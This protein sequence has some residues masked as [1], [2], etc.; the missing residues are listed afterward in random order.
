MIMDGTAQKRGRG[1]EL[2][3]ERR[4]RHSPAR[5]WEWLTQPERLATWL[6]DVEID[7]QRGGRYR[8]RWL[9]AEQASERPMLI[10]EIS[11]IEA[12]RLLLVRYDYWA[13]E[14]GAAE[15]DRSGVP[16]NPGTLQWELRS[17]DGGCLLTF[18]NVLDEFEELCAQTL[19]GWHVHLDFLEDALDGGAVDWENWPLDRWQRHYERYRLQEAER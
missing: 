8:L 16:A 10:G 17:I 4:L 11:E 5:V 13:F 1:Y 3:F 14:D 15:F 9:N 18:V 19:A 7:P 2:R 6:G 12:P